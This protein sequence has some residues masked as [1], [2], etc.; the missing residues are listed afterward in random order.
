MSTLVVT[1]DRRL[2]PTSGP[3]VFAGEWCKTYDAK[4]SWLGRTHST[5]PY[6]WCDRQ[7]ARRDAAELSEVYERI[8]LS[9]AV[10]LNRL[11]GVSYSLND[12]RLMIGFWVFRCVEVFFDRY[13]VVLTAASMSEIE[14]CVIP[15]Y[16]KENW[17][18]STMVGLLDLMSG[19]P[20]NGHL[21]G[22]IISQLKPFPFLVVELPLTDLGEVV[23]QH[24]RWK[25]RAAL[26]CLRLL[27][28]P[29]AKYIFKSSYLPLYQQ[30]S[31][32]A[33]L[34]TGAHVIPRL[35]SF[36]TDYKKDVRA[37]LMEPVRSD[38]EGLIHNY[39]VSVAPKIFIE[40]FAAIQKNVIASLPR[41]PLAYIT[42][43]SFCDDSFVL[44]SAA[45]RHKFG[46]KVVLTQ[47]GGNYG[48]SLWSPNEAHETKVADLYLS[49]GWSVK[50][51]AEVVPAIA[52]K[53][54][55]LDPSIRCNP[56]G[57]ILL[58]LTEMDRYAY[59]NTCMPFSTNFL[60]YIEQQRAFM[61]ALTPRARQILL[62]RPQPGVSHWGLVNRLKDS[63]DWSFQVQTGGAKM[64][65]YLKRCRLF[66]GTA[67]ATTPLEALAANF[68]SVLF[69]SP[70]HWELRAEAQPYFDALI[71]AKILHYSPESAAEHI[72]AIFNDVAG[73][74]MTPKVQQARRE[75]CKVYART[76]GSL[77]REWSAILKSKTQLRKPTQSYHVLET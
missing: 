48:S 54:S 69:W 68:P 30:M 62:V 61:Q 13:Q 57:P 53:L 25:S 49:W 45:A 39:V 74:W 43:N 33:A 70:I 15:S 23:P 12:W 11:H 5:L 51:S 71:Q 10:K 65:K 46:T 9:L 52:G 42:A 7:K 72:E 44:H 28:R 66:V 59:S 60:D 67:N 56:D 19:D 20:F 41:N 21:F 18:P 73:W 16:Y 8:L 24:P 76:G 38:L 37:R 22:Y 32:Y 27:H 3:L 77:A 34:R 26:A 36:P 58:V 2:W 31:L 47:H 17:A 55:S 50:A 40:G 63:V 6:H 14:T 4:S 35:D 64:M 29:D 75:F 1:A